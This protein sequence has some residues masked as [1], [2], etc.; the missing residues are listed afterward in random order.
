MFAQAQP[1]YTLEEYFELER[2]S[3][4][5]YEYWHG[6]VF[7][8]SGVSPEHDQIES[9][10]NFHLRAKLTGRDCRVFLA[11]IRLKV[12]SAPPYRYADMSALCGEAQ[13]EEIGGIRA[14]TNPTLIVEILSPST[15]AYDR[16]DKFTHYKSIP[17]FSEYLLVAQHRP[18]ITHLVKQADGS[19]IYNEYNDLAAVVG[20]VS[21]NCELPMSEV[22]ENVSF[23]SDKS[24]R[25][26]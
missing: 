10:L 9:N 5:R 14:V 12:P 15:E 11:N 21:L 6:E 1:R 26:N 19:W 24:E 3:E 7:C 2:R 13:F 17:S 20:L 4:E 18:H 25:N 22:Y 16:G 23:V 8:M